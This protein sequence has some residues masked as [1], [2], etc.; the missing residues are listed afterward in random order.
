MKWFTIA[1]FIV[2]AFFTIL[3][4]SV[5]SSTRYQNADSYVKHKIIQDLCNNTENEYNKQECRIYKEWNCY[6]E[7]SQRCSMTRYNIEN[8]FNLNK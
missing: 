2:L 5:D 8:C 6:T 3:W 1:L 4:L 7:N